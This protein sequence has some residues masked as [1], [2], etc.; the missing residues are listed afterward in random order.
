MEYLVL[1]SMLSEVDGFCTDLRNV[2][3]DI[4]SIIKHC[5]YDPPLEE[6]NL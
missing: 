5:G 4:L 1:K 3:V 6:L 2:I